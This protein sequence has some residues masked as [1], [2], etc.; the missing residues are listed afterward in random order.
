MNKEETVDVDRSTRR[1]RV[2]LR[3]A[4]AVPLACVFYLLSVGPAARLMYRSTASDASARTFE[5]I[6]APVIWMQGHTFLGRVIYRYVD[7]W[8]VIDYR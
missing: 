2:L 3:V 4:W 7:L 5:V 6:Y 1:K 8:G